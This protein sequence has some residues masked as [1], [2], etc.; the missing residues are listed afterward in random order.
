[1]VMH[2]HLEECFRQIAPPADFC[3]L[4]FVHERSEVLSVRQNVLQPVS[5]SEDIGVMLTVFEKGGDGLR[6]HQRFDSHWFAP[7]C[8]ASPPKWGTNAPF[9]QAC[10]I[11]GT[12]YA[13][14]EKRPTKYMPMVTLSRLALA[15]LGGNGDACYNRPGAVRAS[16]VLGA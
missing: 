16:R 3:S 9:G 6:G 10:P 15:L 11:A 5:A 8:R 12:T 2:G 1:M 13:L 7:R 14:G 4:R